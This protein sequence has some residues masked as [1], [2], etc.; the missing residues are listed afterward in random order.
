MTRSLIIRAC[1]AVAAITA[2]TCCAFNSRADIVTQHE[3]LDVVF[4]SSTSNGSQ[5]FVDIGSPNLDSGNINSATSFTI[6]NRNSTGASVGSHT[7][8]TAQLYGPGTSSPAVGS[9]LS[10]GNAAFGNLSSPSITEQTNVAGKRSF[11]VLGK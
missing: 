7:G 3:V 5:A 9:I 8:L 2:V 1:G 10:F 11:Y 4:M 6:G